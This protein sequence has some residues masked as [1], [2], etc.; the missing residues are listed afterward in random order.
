MASM[1]IFVSFSEAVFFGGGGGLSWKNALS[2]G[3][4]EKWSRKWFG[5]ERGMDR[6][7]CKCRH[8]NSR[9]SQK[10]ECLSV[11]TR[12]SCHASCPFCTNT[13]SGSVTAD[14]FGSEEEQ[15]RPPPHPVLYFLQNVRWNK[16]VQKG[17]TFLFC[18]VWSLLGWS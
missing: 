8:L 11:L 3:R 13:D 12:L 7:C 6:I 18:W 9:W 10:E 5:A 2:N 1:Y 14:R 16:D 15:S 17:Q 4:G